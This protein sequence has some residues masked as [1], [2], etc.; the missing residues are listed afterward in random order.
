M[1]TF[2][3]S[4]FITGIFF[5]LAALTAC[6]GGSGS[7]DGGSNK[8][9]Q[10]KFLDS[11]VQGARFKTA[12][13]SGITDASG[14]FT[15]RS[16][17]TVSFYIGDILLGQA[18]GALVI[19]PVELVPA[20][21]DEYNET[22]SNIARFLQT[23]DD[24]GNADNGILITAVVAQQASGKSLDFTLSATAF[25][26]DGGVQTLIASMTAASTAGAR[27]LVSAA[28]AQSHLSTTIFS[29]LAGSW[30]GTFA[31]NESGTWSL[32]VSQTGRISGAGN[33]SQT[34][35]FSIFGS[36]QSSG[37][38]AFASGGAGTASFSGDF[39]YTN[40]IASG[41]WTISGV[42]GSG[43]WSGNKN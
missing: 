2:R 3:I 36:L 16:G 42:Q 43:T 32:T 34:G 22:V 37:D 19:T 31:G 33:S 1:R 14:S 25:G 8:L 40:G 29:A 26:N 39:S 30:N 7:D 9:K 5:L 12:T 4:F 18:R 13:Q 41:N 28:Q 35:A 23:L 20:A 38:A 15:Y 24:D 27:T 21:V 10:G 6:G 17:E 11:A